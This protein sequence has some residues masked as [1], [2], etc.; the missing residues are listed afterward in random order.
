MDNTNG[1]GRGSEAKSSGS[2]NAPEVFG[3]KRPWAILVRTPSLRRPTT[4]TKR[5]SPEA[6]LNQ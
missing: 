4:N 6:I 1:E 3:F 2:K 5:L